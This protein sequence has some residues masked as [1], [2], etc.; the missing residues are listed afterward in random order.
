MTHNL[1]AGDV[2]IDT[3]GGENTPHKVETV[4]DDESVTLHV[5]RSETYWDEVTHDAEDVAR[6]LEE[7]IYVPQSEFG[8]EL[9]VHVP[10][11]TEGEY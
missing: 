8:G 11:V 9:A 6:C 3:T 5:Y 2:L 1:E 10:G 7:G 4:H